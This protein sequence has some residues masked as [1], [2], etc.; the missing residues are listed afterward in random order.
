LGELDAPLFFEVCFG[1]IMYAFYKHEPLYMVIEHDGEAIIMTKFISE[2]K[3]WEHQALELM[4][5]F[6]NTIKE[7]LD[8]YFAGTLRA[9]DLSI[10]VAGTEFEEL[11][12]NALKTIP[13]GTT[14]TYADL[15]KQIGKPDAFRAV[16]TAC[17]KNPVWF[18]LPC[19]RVIGSDGEMHGYAGGLEVK[20]W[21]L[22]H[23]AKYKA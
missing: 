5:W 13:Q 22:A 19:H 12:W 4:H 3:Y 8:G 6:T 9:F 20:E 2:E 23:E 1:V 17:G 16:G 15:A 11:V 21:L 18:F 14:I 7:Q 10:R